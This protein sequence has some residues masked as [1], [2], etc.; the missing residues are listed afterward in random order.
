MWK[1]VHRGKHQKLLSSFLDAPVLHVSIF[2]LSLTLLRLMT[3]EAKAL[4]STF[5]PIFKKRRR[6]KRCQ[7]HHTAPVLFAFPHNYNVSMGS[8]PQKSI[9]MQ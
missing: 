5:L 6:K 8:I 9:S 3:S 2:R 7:S 4:E 1:Y